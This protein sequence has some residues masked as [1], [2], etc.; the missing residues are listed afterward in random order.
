MK[1]DDL[2]K[3]LQKRVLDREFLSWIVETL[4]RETIAYISEQLKI[5]LSDFQIKKLE[6]AQLRNQLINNH[7]R[8]KLVMLDIL[9]PLF[10]YIDIEE[11]EKELKK[12]QMKEKPSEEQVKEKV[13]NE[14]ERVIQSGDLTR[15]E[16]ATLYFFRNDYEQALTLYDDWLEN[17]EEEQ[18][19]KEKKKKVQKMKESIEEQQKDLEKTERRL[20]RLEQERAQA[21][22]EVRELKEELQELRREKH[23]DKN[24]YNQQLAESERQAE[25]AQQ[26][27]LE[28]RE[29]LEQ[30]I[31]QLE[32]KN[33]ALTEEIV[34][35]KE[36][37]E[38]VVEGTRALD[39]PL[40]SQWHNHQWGSYVIGRLADYGKT[41]THE[42]I[43]INRS[44]ILQFWLK[45]QSMPSDNFPEEVRHVTSWSNYLPS[46]DVGDEFKDGE[47]RKKL[48]REY[49]EQYVVL[50]KIEVHDGHFKAHDLHMLPRKET[51]T[52]NETFEMIPVFHAEFNQY[53]TII[54]FVEALQKGAFIGRNDDVSH[55]Y[56]H[57]HYPVVFYREKNGKVYAAG[58]FDSFHYAHGGFRFNTAEH[59]TYTE[60]PSQW[61]DDMYI[62]ENVA[63]LETTLYEQLLAHIEQFGQKEEVMKQLPP[64]LQTFQLSP[65]V[66]STI[67]EENEWMQRWIY[68]TERQQLTYNVEDLYNFHT[69]VKSGGLT[70]LAGMSGTGKSQLVETYQRSLGLTDE[71]FLFIPVSP[72]WTDDADL[73][74]Y[75]DMMKNYYRPAATGLVDLLKRAEEH[76]EESFIVCFDEMNLARIE[77]YFSQFLSVLERDEEVRELTLYNEAL[78]PVIEN[79][80]EYPPKVTIGQNVFFTGTVNLDESTHVLSDKVLDRANVMTLKVE[81]FQRFLQM[82]DERAMKESIDFPKVAIQSFI[83]TS[84]MMSLSER[85][86]SF[87]WDV[88]E[89]LA[90]ITLHAGIGPR[91]VR[92]I[93][94]YMRNAQTLSEETLSTQRAFDLQFVQRIGSKIRGTEE[95]LRH[96]VGMY[97]EVEEEVKES[98]LFSLFDHYEDLSDFQTSRQLI[99]EKAKELT[100]NGYAF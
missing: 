50:F 74:G 61:I 25:V 23:Q 80:D 53:T 6:I 76:P 73:L 78:A 49:L 79:S 11:K 3:E 72:T 18:K 4:D 60:I 56:R 92:R 66:V 58:L 97:D 28:E 68:E 43:F 2:S 8:K 21:Q 44:E 98:R 20:Q 39:T 86:L 75:V 24:L 67:Q 33:E 27:L 12:E 90:T 91:I 46:F 38:Q 19:Q 85:E 13:E 71:Q 41:V 48:L 29:R 96:V 1:F 15:A 7:H 35:L 40:T 55:E 100:R 45:R 95:M 99:A 47:E 57:D 84:P 37:H 83:Q 36:E 31:T 64:R 87:L 22:Q 32:E 10:Q 54:E 9:Y 93:D 89:L 52:G 69:C 94:R 88:H 17:A 65:T 30:R 77:H 34:H 70:I 81:P 5:P 62:L 59:V 51:F 14:F 16:R 26:Q 63:F 82:T 42:P